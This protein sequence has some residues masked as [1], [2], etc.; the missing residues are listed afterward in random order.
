MCSDFFL[1]SCA[2]SMLYHGWTGCCSDGGPDTHAGTVQV[3]WSNEKG[4]I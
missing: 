3:G 4:L 2:A 1:G